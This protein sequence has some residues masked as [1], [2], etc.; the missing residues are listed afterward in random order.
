MHRAATC[1]TALFAFFIAQLSAAAC[2]AEVATHRSEHF[3]LTTDVDQA[4]V[5]QQLERL[6]SLLSYLADYWGKPVPGF[7]PGLVITL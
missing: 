1:A 7:D 6:E 5:K 3:V 4:E 2:L